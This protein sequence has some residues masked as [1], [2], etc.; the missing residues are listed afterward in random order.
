MYEL[1]DNSIEEMDNYIFMNKIDINLQEKSSNTTSKNKDTFIGSWSKSF[2]KYTN[3]IDKQIEF[4]FNQN[5]NVFTYFTDSFIFPIEHKETN[6]AKIYNNLPGTTNNI[7][8]FEEKQ[9]EHD[10]DSSSKKGKIF[11]LQKKIKRNEPNII[12]NEIPKK[13]REDNFRTGI[14]RNFMNY[15]KNLIEEMKKECKCILYLEKFPKGFILQA[16]KK[17]NKHYLEYTLEELFENKKLYEKKD[18][19]DIYSINLKV[20]N[21]LKLEKNK[22]IMEKFGYDKILKMKYR[23]LYEKYLQSNE[24]K[25]YRQKINNLFEKKGKT[26]AEKIEIWFKTFLD[27]FKKN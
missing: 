21:E 1:E 6:D 17:S 5:L 16:V 25:Q 11:F 3:E 4:S 9:A 22:E 14:G 2:P 7:N 18:P 15:L 8:I 12:E 10:E 19:H 20:I 24:Y 26:E 23:E 27:R 13:I